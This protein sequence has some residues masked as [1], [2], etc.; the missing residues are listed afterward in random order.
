MKKSE[1]HIPG[2]GVCYWTGETEKEWLV[3]MVGTGAGFYSIV[4]II[5][6]EEFREFLP[7]M[8]L[9]AAAEI[10]PDMS[11]KS[12]LER[13]EVD[14][15]AT[16]EEMQEAHPSID[17]YVELGNK[18]Y[19]LHEIRQKL[20]MNVSLMDHR[21]AIFFCGLRDMARIRAFQESNL[22]QQRNLLQAIFD[23][24]REDMLV[25]DRE[26]RIVDLN[27]NV[28]SRT[29][30]SKEEL[31]GKHCWE[32]LKMEGGS[33][34][35]SHPDKKCAFFETLRTGRTAE[36]MLTRVDGEGQLMYFRVYSYPIFNQHG[37][38][39]NVMIMHRD[40]TARTYKER[41][42]HQRD[43]LAVIGEMSTYL[44]HEI[45][46]PLFAL[47][48]FAHSLLRSP[49]LDKKEREKVEIMAE[50]TKRLDH[51]LSSMLSFVK[52]AKAVT[53]QVDLCTLVSETVDLMTI[54]YGKQG[55]EFVLKCDSRTPKVRGD[56]EMVKQCLVNL[57][58]NS[59]EAMPDGGPITVSS[60]I[61][62]TFVYL[63]VEDRG[64]GMSEKD[65]EKVFSPFYTTKEKGCGLGL[66]MIKKIVE[67][68]GGEIDIKSRL[69]RGT[70]VTMRLPPVLAVDPELRSSQ[71][72]AETSE[73]E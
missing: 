20:P 54:G 13:L 66:A 47:G 39:A 26:G 4:D 14:I 67:D 44:A 11:R 27:R 59:I 25:L 17:L 50:E 70:V 35:C 12:L 19:R 53:G 55:Y 33:P 23:E 57:I 37:D 16:F 2:N 5:R 31:I 24:V 29:G 32:T 65:L 43:K 15:Y 3:G 18:P 8:R 58:K 38:L 56:V 42:Q 69:D 62:G 45:R 40:I 73:M 41:H 61:D 9:V 51:M 52:P 34:L 7:P 46:N 21:E 60:G 6:N 1:F 48:G 63:R 22:N 71:E 72:I 49:N 36:A 28:W 10:G 64:L 30:K 68:Y